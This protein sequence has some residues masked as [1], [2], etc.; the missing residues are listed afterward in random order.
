MPTTL[1]PPAP[2]TPAIGVRPV[3][4]TATEFNHLGAQG[5]LAGRRAF[6]LNGVIWEQGAMN[7]PHANALELVTEAVRAAFGSG[8]RFR[9]RTPLMLDEFNNPMPDVFV[10]AGRPGSHPE[11]PTTAALV[12]EISDTTLQTDLTEK[13]ETYATAGIGDYW[14]LDLNARQLIVFRDPAPLTGLGATAYAT[15]RTLNPGDTV[16][17]LAAPTATI[18]VSALLP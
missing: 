6:L 2:V 18:S 7:P 11:H 5:F 1:Q 12:V 17:P 4:W 8:W 9:I 3:L 14:V 10:V 16:S 15:R 13:A